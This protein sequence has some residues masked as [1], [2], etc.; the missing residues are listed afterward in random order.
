ME[1]STHFNKTGSESERRW[2]AP[3]GAEVVARRDEDYQWRVD[4]GPENLLGRSFR[5]MRDLR[6]AVKQSGVEQKIESAMS[7]AGTRQ[8]ATGEFVCTASFGGRNGRPR[9]SGS[10]ASAEQARD[11]L[12]KKLRKMYTYAT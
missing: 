7:R 3:G 2:T 10:G 11:C 8:Q 6:A 4:R 1:N 5:H 9:L 12:R